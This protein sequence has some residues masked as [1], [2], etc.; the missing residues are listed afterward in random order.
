M[1]FKRIY[2]VLLIFAF[3]YQAKGQ[4]RLITGKIS[5]V[6][7]NPLAGVNVSAKDYP[8]ITTI[9]GVDGEFRLEVFDFTKALVFAFTNMKTKEVALTD[10]IDRILV[11]MEYQPLKNPNPW[12]I[13]LTIF[14]G[15]SHVY[16]SAKD[17]HPDWEYHGDPGIMS[18]L[19][20]EYFFTQNIGIGSGIGINLYNSSDYAN[21]LLNDQ[22]TISRIDQDGDQYYLYTSSSSISEKIKVRALSFPIKAKL[23]FR[24]GKKWSFNADFG[25]KIVNIFSAKVKASGDTEWRAYY[26]Q[27]NVV[28]YDVPDY[29]F[30]QYDVDSE[31]TLLDYEKL[32]YSIIGSIGISRRI[33]KKMNL[34]VGFFL[35]RGLTDIKYNQP[36]HE[37]DFLNIV[38]VVDETRLN[39]VGLTVGLRYQ[40]TNKQ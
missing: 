31:N 23:R 35:E 5:D 30:T 29:G 39:A 1:K 6:K 28:I 11:T 37:A 4:D 38:G 24:P 10:T 19:E 13:S 17:D 34:D 15:Q 16:S 2:V 26:P 3:V 7:G 20:I 8:S 18:S 40:I 22:N 27:Y 36:V 33:N 32:N 21:D 25:L 9:S 14:T 12:S